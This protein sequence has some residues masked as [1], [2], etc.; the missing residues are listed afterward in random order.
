MA[1][2]RTTRGKAQIIFIQVREELQREAD[3][4]AIANSLV[5]AKEDAARRTQVS[6]GEAKKSLAER[7]RASLEA[8]ERQAE[9]DFRKA[10]ELSRA[11][12]AKSDLNYH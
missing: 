7:Q 10:L 11:E 9:E 5:T 4:A 12:A 8:A 1:F 6:Q 2:T 3:E